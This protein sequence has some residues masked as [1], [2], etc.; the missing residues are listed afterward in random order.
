MNNL[1]EK[2]TVKVRDAFI[3]F[4]IAAIISMAVKKILQKEKFNVFFNA[5]A[6]TLGWIIGKMITNYIDERQYIG[7]EN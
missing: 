7:D 6:M 2:N 3:Y 1:N 5:L 4:S